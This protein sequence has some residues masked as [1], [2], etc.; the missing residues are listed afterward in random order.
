[1]NDTKE[2]SCCGVVNLKQAK[3]CG[4]CGTAF[5]VE[6]KRPE[7]CPN[8]G[9]PLPATVTFCIEC[10]SKIADAPSAAPKTEKKPVRYGCDRCGHTSLMPSRY[11]EMCG[12]T[13]KPVF[14][15]EKPEKKPV[16]SGETL[17]SRTEKPKSD[18]EKR[19]WIIGISA[20]LVFS[21]LVSALF[22]FVIN[23]YFE[24]QDSG[25]SDRSDTD[26][27]ND[28]NNDNNGNINNSN[29]NNNNN[30]NHGSAAQNK[31][32]PSTS[33]IERAL[34]AKNYF[35]LR[36]YEAE[37]DLD[38]MP[39][40]AVNYRIYDATRFYD[41]YGN[42][43]PY[44]SSE[45]PESLMDNRDYENFESIYF[46]YIQ[47]DSASSAK[48]AFNELLRDGIIEGSYSSESGSN[49]E[50]AWQNSSAQACNTLLSRIDGVVL[51]M[52][53]NWDDFQDAGITYDNAA[54]KAME[55]LGF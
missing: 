13:M 15:E 5:P 22:N 26:G 30:S 2:C 44:T 33:Q 40:G 39:N 53:A 34:Q 20:F 23:P 18:Q 35:W 36:N 49:W 17:K 19:W 7:N 28:D 54:I 42:I 14:S 10:G 32:I 52:Y 25:Y 47:F 48:E 46:L 1:M 50:R 37:G 21:L 6:V 9:T 29:Q 11:C 16:C 31:V 51:L 41:E 43:H 24:E 55:N 8:C 27:D 4:G 3:F 12:G 38:D 45:S